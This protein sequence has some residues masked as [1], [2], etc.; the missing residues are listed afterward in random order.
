MSVHN[1]IQ[2]EVGKGKILPRNASGEQILTVSSGRI[3]KLESIIVTNRSGD[4]EV[5]IWD[6]I[7]G[8]AQT[9][10][11]SGQEMLRV[12]VGAVKT[13]AMGD[14]FIKGKFFASSVFVFATVSGTWVHVGGREYAPRP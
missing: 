7:S 5:T 4:C 9:Y 12:I 2:V 3:F 1:Y 11:F 14:D 13:E 10:G 6:A 8:G